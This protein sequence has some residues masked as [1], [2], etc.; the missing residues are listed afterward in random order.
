MGGVIP[1]TFDERLELIVDPALLRQEELYTN[2]ARLDR[3]I[4]LRTRDYVKIAKP[5]FEGIAQRGASSQTADLSPAEPRMELDNT[6]KLAIYTR[7]ADTG[8]MPT[9]GKVAEAVGVPVAEVKASYARLYQNRVLVL[10]PDG[11][12]IR[13]APPFSGVPTQHLV[14]AG[15]KEYFANCAWDALGILA[16]L[17]RAGEVFSRCE[18]TLEPLHLRVNDN[19]PD[20]EPCV[21]HF[22]VP[23]ALWWRDIVFT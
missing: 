21:I 6:V 14:R 5:R 16:A 9:I 20:P 3:S 10:Q 19:G 15:G 11:I 1:F 7:V 2:A 22:A 4:A 18:Q 23:A 13:M 17:H 8:K 12:S